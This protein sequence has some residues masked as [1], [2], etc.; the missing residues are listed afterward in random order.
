MPILF[1]SIKKKLIYIYLEFSFDFLANAFSKIDNDKWSTF[2]IIV[3]H[4]GVD[5][6]N[7][8]FWAKIC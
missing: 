7:Y 1:L 6:V 2:P 3:F 4:D 5:F 8:K